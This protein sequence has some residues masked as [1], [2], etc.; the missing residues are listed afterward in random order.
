M[1]CSVNKHV[2]CLWVGAGVF[3]RGLW[4]D[5]PDVLK[6][7]MAKYPNLYLSFTPELVAGKYKGITRE[8]ALELAE[9]FPHRIV[10]GTTVRGTFQTPPP[11][12]FGESTHPPA[13][14]QTHEGLIALQLD[15][16]ASAG[17]A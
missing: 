2:K 1:V 10:L 12:E 3:A 5:Y 11:T 15:L 14:L 9:N 17:V 8:V 6:G 7:L 16:I 13:P 4:S